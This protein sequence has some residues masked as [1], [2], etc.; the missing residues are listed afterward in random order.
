[1]S[2]QSNPTGR[3]PGGRRQA[4][5]PFQELTSGWK[6]PESV[7]NRVMHPC[8]QPKKS[9][10]NGL[11][12]AAQDWTI[13]NSFLFCHNQRKMILSFCSWVD[14]VK[15]D[16]LADKCCRHGLF[17]GTYLSDVK[18]TIQSRLNPLYF[19]T[20]F[21]LDITS[22]FQPLEG[23]LQLTLLPQYSEQ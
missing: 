11:D 18:K 17:T 1:M 23:A 4:G 6:Q 3:Q 16:Y 21:P 10:K 2:G 20:L 19:L 5:L 15:C 12:I 22:I 14:F 13:F 8:H 7:N 9:G